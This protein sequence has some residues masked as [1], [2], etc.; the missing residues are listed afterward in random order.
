MEVRQSTTSA[1]DEIDLVQLLAILWRQKWLI[2]LVTCLCTAIGI[3][4]LQIAKPTYEAKAYL[5]PPNIDDIAALNYGRTNI[6]SLPLPVF[7]VSDVYDVFSQNLLSESTKRRF[8]NKVWLPSLPDASGKKVSKDALFNQFN[9]KF[10][11]QEIPKSMPTKYMVIVRSQNP[12]QAV[13]WLKN[14]IALVKENTSNALTRIVQSQTVSVI[15]DLELKLDL[16][17]QVAK[18]ERMD[19]LVQLKEAINIANSMEVNAQVTAQG[20]SN[21]A[22]DVRNVTDPSLMYTRG[23]KAL[24]AE[25]KNLNSRESDAPFVPN[26]RQMQTQLNLYKNIKVRPQ[27]FVFFRLDGGIQT[28]DL[29]IAPKKELIILMSLIFG[30]MLGITLAMLRNFFLLKPR[31][32]N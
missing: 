13:I 15:H 20:S 32:N 24:E 21:V 4:Y 23:T 16:A 25:V 6:E 7:K 8:F 11:I 19:R 27:D 29:P 30:L 1:K 2:I 9:K 26:F 28:P 12:A 3:A 18:E 5:L 31:I 17:K 10:I 22:S 14:Y